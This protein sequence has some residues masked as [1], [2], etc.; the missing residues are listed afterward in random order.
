MEYHGIHHPIC[1]YIEL[2]GEFGAGDKKKLHR[3]M[4]WSNLTPNLMVM[5]EITELVPYRLPD[6]L[7]THGCFECNFG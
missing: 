4:K 6:N 5:T 3:R 7:L 2:I 1:I